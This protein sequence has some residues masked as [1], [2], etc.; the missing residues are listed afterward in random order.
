MAA[1]YSFSAWD[2][3]GSPMAAP[4]SFSACRRNVDDLVMV[5]DLDLCKAMAHLFRYAKLAVEPAAAASTAALLG[6]MR[7]ELEGQRVSL[8]VCGANIDPTSFCHLVAEGE[9]A[10]AGDEAPKG[11][12][13]IDRLRKASRVV[14]GE[15]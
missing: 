11:D 7:D 14:R 15:D 2:S 3:L 5:S 6:P 9:R 12:S 1:P 8:M 13:L 10:L 4:Y